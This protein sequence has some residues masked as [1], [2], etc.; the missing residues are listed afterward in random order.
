[1]DHSVS[2]RKCVVE[3]AQCVTV[4]ASADIIAISLGDVEYTAAVIKR[5]TEQRNALADRC[6]IL[7]SKIKE[8]ETYIL[9]ISEDYT[10]KYDEN[11]ELQVA[12]NADSLLRQ[13]ADQPRLM[14]FAE[15]GNFNNYLTIDLEVYQLEESS[16]SSNVVQFT[17][18]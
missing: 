15:Q 5:V 17:A 7:E 3:A 10:R 14:K 12:L 8:L 13:T 6:T 9:G 18:A 16:E 1:M 11:I 4:S 2:E